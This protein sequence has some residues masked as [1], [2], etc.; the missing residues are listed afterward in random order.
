MQLRLQCR[1]AADVSELSLVF[2]VRYAVLLRKVKHTSAEHSMPMLV[3][4]AGF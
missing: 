3:L 4:L 2:G 1:N